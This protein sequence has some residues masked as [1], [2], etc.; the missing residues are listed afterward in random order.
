MGRIESEPIR[1]FSPDFA[2]IFEWGE[3]F[4]GF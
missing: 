2:D 1:L 4:Q 3:T